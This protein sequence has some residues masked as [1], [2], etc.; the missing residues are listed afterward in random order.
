M[1]DGWIDGGWMEA[2]Y[3]TFIGSSRRYRRSVEL[4]GISRTPVQTRPCRLE[5]IVVPKC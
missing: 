2:L 4:S 1:L 5:T 3:L